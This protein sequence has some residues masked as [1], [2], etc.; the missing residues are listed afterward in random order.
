MEI[1]YIL[2]QIDSISMRIIENAK[3][4]ILLFYGEMGVGKTTLITSLAKH[5]GVTDNVSSPTFSIVNEYKAKD[6]ITI[7]HFDAYRIEQ[8]E[9]IL[10]IGFE[11]YIDQGDWIFIEWPEKIRSFIPE[12]SQKIHISM[13]EIGERLIKLN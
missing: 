11:E 5:L 4:N 3:S 9:E 10:D 12:N 6:D 2:S 7:Y 13:N 1:T 8:E